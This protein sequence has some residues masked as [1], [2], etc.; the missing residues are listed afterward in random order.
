M[1]ILNLEGGTAVEE[2]GTEAS[3][4]LQGGSRS[5]NEYLVYVTDKRCD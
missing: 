1:L 3:P 2:Q 5:H 4:V